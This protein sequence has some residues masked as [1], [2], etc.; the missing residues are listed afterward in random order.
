MSSWTCDLCLSYDNF[1]SWLTCG[2][3]GKIRGELIPAPLGVVPNHLQATSQVKLASIFTTSVQQSQVKPR[4]HAQTA[5]NNST[6]AVSRS[7][8]SAHEATS[9]AR[10]PTSRGQVK[11]RPHAQTAANNSTVAVSRSVASA[12][13][14]TSNA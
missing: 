13:K 11:P 4:P 12:H 8:A 5:A 9:N 6:V 7:V 10:F 1:P 3:C 2:Y 14:A